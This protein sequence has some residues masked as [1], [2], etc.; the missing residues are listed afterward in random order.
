M[1]MYNLSDEQIKMLKDNVQRIEGSNISSSK[2][3]AFKKPFHFNKQ[4][5]PKKLQKI[6]TEEVRRAETSGNMIRAL[7][8]LTKLIYAQSEADD[9]I[10][11][12]NTGFVK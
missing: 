9:I 1:T 7:K 8:Q 5:S 12:G 3:N 11:K 2:T 4:H 10:Q 6:S